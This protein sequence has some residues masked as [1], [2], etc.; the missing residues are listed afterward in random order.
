MQFILEFAR[1]TEIDVC[2]TADFNRNN[3]YK[4]KLSNE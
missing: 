4:K 1:N 3:F 2:N